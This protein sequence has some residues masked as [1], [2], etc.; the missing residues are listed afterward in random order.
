M[1]N[2]SSNIVEKTIL[3]LLNYYYIFVKNHLEVFLLIGPL[4]QYPGR[5]IRAQPALPDRDCSV[6]PEQ[7]RSIISLLWPRTPSWSEIGVLPASARWGMDSSLGKY[8]WEAVLI[9]IKLEKEEVLAKRFSVVRLSFFS[10]L[11]KNRLFLKLFLSVSCW[12]LLIS[13]AF[14]PPYIGANKE[15]KGIYHHFLPFLP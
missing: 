3:P 15:S 12:Q 13:V 10:S 9:G 14:C 1:S 5:V 2:C 11:I 8:L 6:P 7:R 4:W